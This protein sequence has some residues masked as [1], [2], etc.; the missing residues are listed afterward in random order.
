MKVVVRPSRA[1]VGIAEGLSDRGGDGN[2]VDGAEVAKPDGPNDGAR[3]GAEV[4]GCSGGVGEELNENVV[5]P[6]ALLGG[7]SGLLGGG[8]FEEADESS[9]FC[10]LA[11]AWEM[12]Y[13]AV[14]AAN[15]MVD[16]TMV[17]IK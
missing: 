15:A 8:A 5:L 1:D 6:V 13:T 3:V 17:R 11:L 10:L 7:E 9:M 16:A 4:D 14:N 12:K 2:D